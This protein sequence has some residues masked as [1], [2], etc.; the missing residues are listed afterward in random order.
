MKG[1]YVTTP[2][3]FMIAGTRVALGAGIGFLAAERLS[4]EQRRAVGLTLLGV[5][6]ISTIPLA[7]EVLFRRETIEPAFSAGSSR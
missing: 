1:R 4:D 5:G 3:L 6:V 7:A 2:E